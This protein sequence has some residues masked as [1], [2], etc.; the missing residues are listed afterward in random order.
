MGLDHIVYIDFICKGIPWL[1]A[2][3]F[4]LRKPI[5]DLLRCERARGP[6]IEKI[7]LALRMKNPVTNKDLRI[8]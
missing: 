2:V 1:V 6:K 5:K 7:G 8:T 4:C 3:K